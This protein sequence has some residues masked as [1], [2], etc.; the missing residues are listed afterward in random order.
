M[1]TYYV[2]DGDTTVE[3]TG[4][5]SQSEAEAAVRKKGGGGGSALI[6]WPLI[7]IKFVSWI[8]GLFFSLGVVGR[9]IQSVLTGLVLGVAV[10]IPLS[11]INVFTGGGIFGRD[12][13][14]T[15]MF[16]GL[17]TTMGILA[18][19]TLLYFYLIYP[20]FKDM[21]AGEFSD[22]MWLEVAW[23][24][25]Y[26]FVT[27]KVFFGLFCYKL[28]HMESGPL[29]GNIVIVI[30][31]IAG[32]VNSI[33]K[34]MPQIRNAIEER[35]E[36]PK[37]PTAALISVLIICSGAF[38]F[39]Y[40]SGAKYKAEGT[41]FQVGTTLIPTVDSNELYKE[42]DKA[43]DVIKKL[44]SNDRLTITGDVIPDPAGSH[45]YIPVEHNGVKG[46]VWSNYFNAITGTA[47]V[48]T[49]DV[50]YYEEGPGNKKHFL[51]IGSKLEVVRVWWNKKYKVQMADVYY[52]GRYM[53]IE[54]KNIQLD[55]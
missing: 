43:S 24:P 48:I 23:I 54:A 25:V 39:S 55:E 10:L 18:L 5:N 52:N 42:A 31:L 11:R 6:G 22:F 47:T 51:P 46:W 3:V 16:I 26:G 37:A 13:M 53:R 15:A 36:L 8:F 32:L 50:F 38:F 12:P 33:K 2:K 30:S 1:G 44:S 27:G 29:I 4:V 21:S 45:Y 28:L 34:L 9:I 19:C 20:V 49:E 40:A 14:T 7:A 35:K 41:V 17:I